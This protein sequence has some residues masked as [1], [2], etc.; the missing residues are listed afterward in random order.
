MTVCA[1]VH[2][3]MVNDQKV[4]KP[5]SF[6]NVISVAKL[7]HLPEHTEYFGVVH[8]KV[9]AFLPETCSHST[10]PSPHKTVV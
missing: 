2:M 3:C 7:R 10:S 8:Q 5:Q 9:Q 1:S 6:L 4:S